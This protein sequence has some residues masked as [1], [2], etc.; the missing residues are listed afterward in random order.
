MEY[1][2]SSPFSRWGNRL[3]KAHWLSKVA[4]AAQLGIKPRSTW[5]QQTGGSQQMTGWDEPGCERWLRI[6]EKMHGPPGCVC[7]GEVLC[8]MTPV[9]PGQQS[10]SQNKSQN[11]I[12]FAKCL[13]PK[14]SRLLEKR[15]LGYMF[16]GTQGIT[17]RLL[18]TKVSDAF[19]N[20]S[21]PTPT[22][23]QV[24]HKAFLFNCI[25]K[26][27][28]RPKETSVIFAGWAGVCA[29][30]QYLRKAST[31]SPPPPSSVRLPQDADLES[32][33]PDRDAFSRGCAIFTGPLSYPR[34]WE[35]V[36]WTHCV[37]CLGGSDPPMWSMSCRWY[38]EVEEKVSPCEGGGRG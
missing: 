25:K 33:G 31:E 19:K 18:L 13:T 28:N 2:L 4:Q 22:S 17:K 11:L 6:T 21:V 23:L 32:P 7:A 14:Q 36:R 37:L 10:K 35:G 1:V 29:A 20:N 15:Q 38:R 30:F 5:L 26:N 9:D 12:D 34:T 16:Y 24:T 3:W 8:R 27:S